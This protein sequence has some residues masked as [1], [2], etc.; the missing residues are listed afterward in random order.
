M[1]TMLNT[2]EWV[3]FPFSVNGINFNS[4]V[5]PLS[6]MYVNVLGVSKEVFVKMNQDAILEIIGNPIT[7]TPKE[8]NLELIRVNEFAS[9]AIIELAGE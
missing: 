1:N 8:L 9:E 5:N 4:V 3:K 7:L 6:Q 2:T